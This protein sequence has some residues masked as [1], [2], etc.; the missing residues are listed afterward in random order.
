MS[1]QS[2][3]DILKRALQKEIEARKA[4][5]KTLDEKSKHFHTLSEELKSTNTKLSNL[6]DEKSSQLQGF[7]DNIL[8][9]YL[10]MNFKGHVLKMNDAA[11]D[12][13]GYDINKERVNVADLIYKEDEKYAFNSF[14]ELTQ[15]GFFHNYTARITTKTNEIKWV[16][17]NASIIFNSNKEPIAAQG[18]IRDITQHKEDEKLLIESKNRLSSLISNLDSGVL[19][20]DENRKIIFINQQ[21]CDIFKIPLLSESLI[22]KD[23]SD[24]IDESQHLFVDSTN[25]KNRLNELIYNKK[26]TLGDELL[27]KDGTVLEQDFI[28]IRKDGGHDGFLWA[29]KDISLKKKYLKSIESQKN[30]Y[31][32]IIANM[33]LGLVEI[34]KTGKILLTNQS[35][36]KMSGYSTA[37]L[38]DKKV[39]Q[40]LPDFGSSAVFEKQKQK[41]LKGESSSYEL[42][43]KT[44]KGNLKH[45]LVSG[46]PNYNLK[47]NI[48]GTI[49]I[50]LD[51]TELKNLENQKEKI[52]KELEKRNNELEEYAHIVSHDLKSPLR[53]I[54]ALTSWIKSDNEGK[55]DAM[56][57]QNFELVEMTLEKMEHLISDIL[58]YSSAGIETKQKEKVNL[59]T[60]VEDL[61]KILFIPKNISFTLVNKLPIVLGDK[62]K[63]QQLFQNLISNA[64]K[65][66]D[67]EK[68]LISINVSESISFYE[69]S[70]KDNGIGI[71]KKYHQKIFKIFNSLQESKNST[72][73]GLSI[74][75]KIVDLYNGEIWIESEP[76]KG[77]TFFFTLKK[78]DG[79][80]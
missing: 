37:E 79:T 33:N 4:S 61:K 46:T 52:L 40:L 43:L 70:V 9:A 26:Q 11:K 66:C 57:L 54:N 73:I 27:M 15:K 64:I 38:K 58:T 16:Q 30:K 23:F 10:V 32:N 29:Y 19:L 42:K 3:I 34:D 49:A 28:P 18:I 75:K 74:V 20:E 7:Y 1:Q 78:Q 65:F 45:W 17:I 60:L 22:G 25:F 80:T 41:R 76:N 67:K 6:L 24:S 63:F 8:D 51:I 35:L 71:E 36:S 69:F 48:I 68:G 44:K 12:L 21:F 14:L 5:E 39:E 31:S 77:T 62:I 72:G 56:T 55:F 53:S 13:F 50:C 47:G 59:N 2:E